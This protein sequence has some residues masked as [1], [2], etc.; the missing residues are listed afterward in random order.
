MIDI[1]PDP[2]RPRGGFAEIT[3]DGVS[4]GETPV[5]IRVFNSFLEKWL[6]PDGW[7][8][9]PHG[10]APRATEAGGDWMRLIVGPD[11]VNQI[12]EDTPI[13]IEIGETAFNTYW[14]DDIN[15]GPDVAIGGD[16]AGTGAKAVATTPKPVTQMPQTPEPEAPVDEDAEA[17]DPPEDDTDAEEV[18]ETEEDGTPP[19]KRGALVMW[20]AAL[21]IVGAGIVWYLLQSAPETPP[22]APPAQAATEPET[23]RPSADP[24]ATDQLTT[25]AAEGFAPLAQQLR[26]CG[27]AIS[28]D[29]AL[30]FVERAAAAEDPDALALFGA[31]YDKSVEEAEIKGT[32]GLSFGD[33]P[34]RAAE[35]YAR[36]AK[37]GSE[38]GRQRLT[39]ICRRLLLEGDTLSQSAHEDFCK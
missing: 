39:A 37:A 15:H 22:E 21:L 12:E 9:N 30:G 20:G 17:E 11:I 7:Q 18:G 10:F 29:A 8:P 34:A 35:Y 3:V 36:A 38:D 19:S 2:K 25:L 6:G 16:L 24:C 5:E 26:G 14:P 28:A 23:P 31:L 27:G 32:I 4:P 13:R 33:D 1:R